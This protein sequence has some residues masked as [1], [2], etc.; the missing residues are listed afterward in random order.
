MRGDD[1]LALNSPCQS[2]FADFFTRSFAG[3]TPQSAA[4]IAS[5]NRWRGNTVGHAVLAYVC[6][7][8]LGSTTG[9]RFTYFLDCLAPRAMTA[10]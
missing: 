4:G 10:C 2:L 6:R 5:P 7:S 8:G 3:M 1:G 9:F